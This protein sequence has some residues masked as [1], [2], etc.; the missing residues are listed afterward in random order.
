MTPLCTGEISKNVIIGDHHVGRGFEP[1]ANLA[2]MEMGGHFTHQ[3]LTTLKIC[4][5]LALFL[6]E[7]RGHWYR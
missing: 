2:I 5:F 7:E 4:H 1:G 3:L 6:I